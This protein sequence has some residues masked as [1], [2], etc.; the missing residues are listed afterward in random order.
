MET[1]A[2]GNDSFVEL[3]RM[4]AGVPDVRLSTCSG[5]LIEGSLTRTDCCRARAQGGLRM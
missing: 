5:H 4:I 3:Q 2:A 1:T